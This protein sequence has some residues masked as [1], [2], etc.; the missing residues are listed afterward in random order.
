MNVMT[1]VIFLVVKLTQSGITWEKILMEDLMLC[2][3]SK[4]LHHDFYTWMDCNFEL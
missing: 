1:S 2:N 4:F 3:C